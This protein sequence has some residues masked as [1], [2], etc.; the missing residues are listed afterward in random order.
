MIDFTFDDGGRADAGFRGKTGDC[1]TRAIAICGRLDY[2]TVYRE[3]AAAMAG[4]GYARSAN[5]YLTR[6]AGRDGRR[7]PKKI[8]R[9][10]IA[11]FGFEKV[12]L[13]RGPRPT[14]TEAH[15]RYG[16]CIVSTRKHV[17]ALVGG[18][19]RDTFDD[20]VYDGSPY[21]LSTEEE[22]KAMSVWVPRDPKS[23]ANG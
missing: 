15:E 13:P 14:Y 9:D 8:Q 19:V 16:D 6:R 20:R 18:S 1:V 17:C 5:A 3:M 22:R 21:G 23:S 11:R 12:R 4:H 2:R 10:V 7:C